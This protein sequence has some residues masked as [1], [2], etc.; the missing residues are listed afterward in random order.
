MELIEEIESRRNK[1]GNLVKW[2]KFYCDCCNNY[3]IRRLVHGKK[4]KFCGCSFGRLIYQNNQ[5]R[6]M[7]E[8]QK[9]RMSN[10]QKGK[11]KTEEH[12]QKISKALKG[13]NHPAYGKKYTEEHKQKIAKA[14]KGR[15]MSEEQ[16]RR[17]SE[18]HK[19]KKQTGEQKLKRSFLFS[20]KNN[21]MYGKT[22]ELSPNWNGG[23]SFEVYPKEFKQI[24]QF[25]YERDNYTC[26][27]PDC[28]HKTDVLDAHHI[29]YNKKNNNPENILTLCRSCHAKTN[30]KSNR[31]YWIEFYQNIMFN[32][33]ME[34]LL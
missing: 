31:Q 12:K 14:N 18:S 5:G 29:D 11:R 17:N 30:G 6:R 26:Q 13:E 33:I 27:Y 24:K 32:R 20:G 9:Q 28:K 19:G 4:Q 25:I 2:G 16:N 7:T 8:K 15:K 22:G 21:P 10:A 34:C 3:V 1:N 23:T